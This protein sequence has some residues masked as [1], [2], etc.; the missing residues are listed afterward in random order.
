M[1]IRGGAREVELQHVSSYHQYTARLANDLIAFSPG[2]SGRKMRSVFLHFRVEPSEPRGGI[3]R[4]DLGGKVCFRSV[5]LRS[6]SRAYPT[7]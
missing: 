5:G 6:Q 7:L 2:K 4:F 1:P 3:G